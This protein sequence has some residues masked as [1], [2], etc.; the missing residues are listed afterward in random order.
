MGL[1]R[2]DQDCLLKVFCYFKDLLYSAN[3]DVF[4]V[5]HSVEEGDGMGGVAYCTPNI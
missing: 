1:L 4:F 3:S 5:L 2:R